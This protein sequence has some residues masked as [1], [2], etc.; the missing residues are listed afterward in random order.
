M[1]KEDYVDEPVDEDLAAAAAEGVREAGLAPRGTEA[2]PPCAL[3]SP[4]F[5]QTCAEIDAVGD[6]AAA[7]WAASS[8]MFASLGDPNTFLMSPVGVCARCRRA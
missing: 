4:A 6:T 2:A 7:V 3:P 8:A 1:L 5:E